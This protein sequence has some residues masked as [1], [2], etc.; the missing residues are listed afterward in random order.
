MRF[1]K[2]KSVLAAALTIVGCS[3]KTVPEQARFEVTP[4]EISVTAEGSQESF[5]VLSTADDWMARSDKEWVKL[6][7]VTAK[8]SEEAVNV[9][10]VVSE[11]SDSESRTAT[12]TVTTMSGSKIYVTVSQE[13]GSG[14]VVGKGISSAEDL[15]GFAKAFNSG[16]GIGAYKVDGE[17]ALMCDIDASSIREWV[18]VGTRDIPFG[19]IFNGNGHTISNIGW[20]VDTDK[21]PYAGFVGYAKNATVKSLTLG[22]DGSS[23]TFSGS[24]A[25]AVGGI[26][27]YATATT[28]TRT[29]SNVSLTITSGSASTCVGG[30]CGHAASSTFIGDETSKANGCV[31]NGNILASFACCEGGIAGRS[32]GT[33][34]NCTS[35]AAV[36]GKYDS[37]G[38]CGPAWGCSSISASGTFT[39]NYGYG[40]V[41]DYDTYRSSPESARPAVHSTATVYPSG[42]YDMT[43]N[44]VDWTQDTYYDW[45]VV[46]EKQLHAGVKYSH[47]SFTGMTRHMHVL[48]IDLS[49][50][51]VEL[52]TAFA[53]E[54]IPNPNGNKNS[55]NGK[56]IRET[57]SDVCSRR[58]SE[59][60]DIIAGVNSGFFDSNDGIARGFHVEE[61][62]PVYVNNPDVSGT[63]GNHAWA[64]TV[65]TDGTASCGQKSLSATLE[66]A[67]KEYRICSVNDTILRHASSKYAVNMFTSRYRQYPHPEKTT[68]VNQLAANVLYVV[69][70]YTADPVKVNAGWAEAKVTA[71]H[72]G[73]GTEL[74]ALPYL[75]SAGQVGFSISPD[76]A[77]E[78]KSGLKV[79]DVIRLR[80]DISVDGV[81]KPIF[82][83]NSSMYKLMT[84]GED[85]S[86]TPGS[87]ASLYSTYDPMTFP[88]V[89][90]DG[91]KVWL[92]EVDGRQAGYSIGVKG[93]EMYRIARKLGGWNVTRLDGGGSSCMWVYD[94]SK[95]AGGIVNSVSDSKGERSCLN[96]LLVRLK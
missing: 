37:A 48:E 7:T 60:Q 91:R 74:T 46:E 75:S 80:V 54:C 8:A 47:C 86:N 65:F 29:A 96:Y 40:H 81:T 92:V 88:V 93:Y 11:N 70:E 30:I 56:N 50:P 62:E 23:V 36:L 89:S 27:G 13:A 5:D 39:S 84:D 79:W 77:P 55:N 12:V 61:C 38:Q 67:G 26:V 33:V 34:T 83:Q 66:A 16:A 32:D 3:P 76:T 44:T 9:R 69:A 53:D 73:T 87:S 95:N 21:Y 71:I 22:S 42:N 4:T 85:A 90:S 64:I 63:L 59:G 10:M 17:V 43:L 52:T 2:V 72:D 15:L 49:D 19:E 58:R 24:G 35:N 68:L 41:G 6:L 78:F 31:S 18:P 25:V 57:L 94:S 45:D 51:S 1:S 20:T 28:V 14:P 82:T